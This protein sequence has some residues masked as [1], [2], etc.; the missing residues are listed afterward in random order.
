MQNIFW[1]V[2]EYVSVISPNILDNY[3][4]DN[5]AEF[6]RFRN[7]IKCKSDDELESM[8]TEII[9]ELLREAQ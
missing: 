7:E 4:K 5:D 3:C 9:Q 1:S 8:I 2:W 6:E